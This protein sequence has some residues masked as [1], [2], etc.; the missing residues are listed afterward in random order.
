MAGSE[1]RAVSQPR[2]GPPEE[3]SPPFNC[4]ASVSGHPDEILLDRLDK[5]HPWPAGRYDQAIRHWDSYVDE[6]PAPFVEGCVRGVE[7]FPELALL[8]ALLSCLRSPATHA[9]A[10]SISPI[11][12]GRGV[13][14]EPALRPA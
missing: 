8:W 5:A 7:G 11:V 3:P 9:R 10:S 13:T 4:S 12:S 2:T 14:P 1:Q 6:N